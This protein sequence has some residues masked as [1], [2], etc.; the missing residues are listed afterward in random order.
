MFF[1]LRDVSFASQEFPV[2]LGVVWPDFSQAGGFGPQCVIG[3]ISA[4]EQVQRNAFLSE[5]MHG[6]KPRSLPEGPKLQ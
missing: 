3:F 6:E 1:S 2:P 4:E 5:G